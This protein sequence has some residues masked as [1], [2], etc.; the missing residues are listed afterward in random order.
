MVV[1]ARMGRVGHGLTRASGRGVGRRERN[2]L[3]WFLQG[4]DNAAMCDVVVSTE[5]NTK[6]IEEERE[7]P[8]FL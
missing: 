4:K 5:S 6:W 8:T 2:I 1:M 3:T 7:I